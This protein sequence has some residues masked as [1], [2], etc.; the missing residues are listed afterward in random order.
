MTRLYKR[1][2]K[3][4]ICEFPALDT[5]VPAVQFEKIKL[6]EW[7][8]QKL[9]AELDDEGLDTVVICQFCI[10]DARYVKGFFLFSQYLMEDVVYQARR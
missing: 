3:C 6:S 4:R 1:K 7:W 5:G 10:W 8:L 9:N 2:Q